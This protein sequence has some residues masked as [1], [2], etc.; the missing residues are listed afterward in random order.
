MSLSELNE[1][2]KVVWGA[3]LKSSE[4][5]GHDFGILEDLTNGGLPGYSTHELAGYIGSIAK[6]GYINIYPP[7]KVNGDY[8]VT[9]FV[10]CDKENK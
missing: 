2:E 8:W 1:R 7:H 4:G 5:N 9:Q 10:I 6:K 3:L